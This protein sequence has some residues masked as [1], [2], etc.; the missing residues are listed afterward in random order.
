M[1]NPAAA[2]LPRTYIA[3]TQRGEAGLLAAIALGARRA[4]EAGWAYHEVPTGHEPERDAPGAVA[5]LLLALA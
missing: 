2:A 3:A 1:R 4:R 5:A